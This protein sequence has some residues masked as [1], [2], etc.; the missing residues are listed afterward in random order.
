MVE[1][2]GDIVAPSILIAPQTENAGAINQS[3]A[4]IFISGSKLH[5][6]E[7]VTVHQITSS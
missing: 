1:V 3:G 2:V 7:G 6:T 4:N 5:F